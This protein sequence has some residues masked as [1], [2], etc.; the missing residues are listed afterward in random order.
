MTRKK[1]DHIVVG[2]IIL[3]GADKPFRPPRAGAGAGTTAPPRIYPSYAKA[4]ATS[5]KFHV[6]NPS[7]AP[8]YYGLDEVEYEKEYLG[9]PN[10][11]SCDI[12][13]CH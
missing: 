2:W 3:D 9:C 12:V 4:K 13:G 10:W 11:P 7:F 1:P 8:V 5:K 6:K